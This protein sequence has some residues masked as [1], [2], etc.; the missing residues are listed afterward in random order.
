MSEPPARKW[1]HWYSPTDT[2]E[3]KK[4]ILKLDLLLVPYAFVLY[5]VKYVDQTNIST[6]NTILRQGTH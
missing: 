5:W 2:P 6:Y 3:E 4:L 1:Y